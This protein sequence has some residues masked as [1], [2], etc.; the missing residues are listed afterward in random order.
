MRIKITSYYYIP[1]RTTKIKW[2]RGFPGG[3]EVKDPPSN[4]GVTGLVPDEGTKTP[5][6]PGQLSPPTTREKSMCHNKNLVEPKKEEKKKWQH[7]MLVSM[8]R[9]WIISTAI[10]GIKVKCMATLENSLA[11]SWKIKHAL[12]NYTH[13]H[14]WQRNKK[15]KSQKNLCRNVYM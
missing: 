15:V 1:I 8:Q 6:T 12:S 7:Q 9:T 13:G 4:S 2:H 10:N 11:V 5:H 14:L 3:A